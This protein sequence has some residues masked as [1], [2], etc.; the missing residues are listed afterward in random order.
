MSID[1]VSVPMIDEVVVFFVGFEMNE[2]E[3]VNSVENK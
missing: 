3:I 2:S 1:D